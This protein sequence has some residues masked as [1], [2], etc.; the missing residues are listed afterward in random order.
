VAKYGQRINGIHQHIGSNV[1]DPPLFA[2]AMRALLGT[3]RQFERLE[4]VDFGGGFGIPYRP[5]EPRLDMRKLG[6]LIDETMAD[7]VL[8][9]GYTPR[10]AFEPGRYLVAEAGTLMVSVTDYKVTPHKTFVGVDSGFNQLLRP[11]MYG[12]YHH[13]E[14]AS[15]PRGR[16]QKVTVAGNVCESG[17]VFAKDRPLAVAKIGD[18]LAIRTA[19]AY[20]ETMASTYN[21]RSLPKVAVVTES[22]QIVTS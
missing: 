13:I 10:L 15:N 22:S 7:F 17:D 21:A 11:A 2:K 6:A 9:A 1:L 16:K 18:L 3:A 4:Y 8:Q 14:N 20:G 19:G 5:G 12:S